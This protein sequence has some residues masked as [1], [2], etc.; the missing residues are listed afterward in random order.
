[1][2]RDQPATGRYQI[3]VGP[4]GH[5]QG[6]DNTIMLEW[7]DTWLKHKNTGMDETRTPM[8]LYELRT[9][10]WINAARYPVVDDYTT[11]YLSPN[12]VLGATRSGRGSDPIAWTS[13]STPGGTLTYSTPLLASGATLAGPVSTTLYA[14]SSNTNLMLIATLTDIAPDGTAAPVT[15]GAVLGSQRALSP[16]KTWRDRDGTVIRPY[17]SQT[18]DDYLTPGAVTRFD[19]ALHP[20][21]WAVLPGH[22][23]RL[24]LTT[25]TPAT[26]CAGFNILPCGLTAPAQASVSGGTYQVQRGPAWPSSVH[27]PLLKA[28][29]FS[30][31]RSAVTPTSGGF[32]QPMNW[33][34]SRNSPCRSY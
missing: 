34:T 3:I 1:M 21:L 29:C 4:W 20:R 11:Y 24:T 2:A 27:L 9:D 19:I 14:S 7:Y 32:S 22:S 10:R 25:Q 18:G 23:L 26:A 28:G 6:L 33:S 31:A 16:Q 8:H 5:G 17:T 30:T 13:P 15:F 12:G